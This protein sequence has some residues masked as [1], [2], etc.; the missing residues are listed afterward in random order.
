MCSLTPVIVNGHTWRSRVFG[1]KKCTKTYWS[2]KHFFMPKTPKCQPD[3]RNFS[4]ILRTPAPFGFIFCMQNR[5]GDHFQST[6][7]LF[8][9]AAEGARGFSTLLVFC[10]ADSRRCRHN[11]FIY[12]ISSPRWTHVQ[13][14][15]LHVWHWWEVDHKKL[16][17]LCRL[18]PTCRHRPT[19]GGV[20]GGLG[21]FP[22]LLLLVLV[23][24]SL[25]RLLLY[26]YRHHASFYFLCIVIFQVNCASGSVF[27]CT[28]LIQ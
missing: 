10:H 13:Q 19:A 17:M 6:F 11:Q 3:V 8:L 15:S 23:L 27:A 24:V 12:L 14:V 9:V 28:N 5:L 22:L 16:L 7:R 20:Q 4:N 25:P 21:K 18:F 2:L 1:M 26:F